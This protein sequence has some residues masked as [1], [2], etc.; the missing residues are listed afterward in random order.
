MWRTMSKLAIEQL[1]PHT[2]LGAKTATPKL[3]EGVNYFARLQ[4]AK[5]GAVELLLQTAQGSLKL[6]LTAAPDIPLGLPLMVTLQRA[7]S[8]STLLQIKVLAALPQE[9]KL[10]PAQAQLLQD[11]KQL[12]LLQ[13]QLQRNAPPALLAAEPFKLTAGLS[14]L[15]ATSP[16]NMPKLL[17]QWSAPAGS[18]SSVLQLFPVQQEQTV[19][20]E[21][22]NLLSPL[23][24]SSSTAA[25]A[26]SPKAPER[27]TDVSW[28]Q[29]LPLLLQQPAKLA[30]L[31]SL[32]EPVLAILQQVRQAQPDGQ[33]LL[34]AAQVEQQLLAALQFQPLQTQ[35]NLQT[36][37]GSL[38]VAIQLLLGHL[39][40]K[41]LTQTRAATAALAQ[42]VAQLDPQQAG[43]LLRALGSH[44]SVLQLAQLQNLEQPQLNQQWF[45]PLAVQQQQESRIVEMLLERREAEQH[46][47][48][49]RQTQWQLSMKFDLA[50]AGQLLAVAKLGGQQLQ[51]QFYTEQRSAL[52]QA[53]KFLPLLTERLHAQGLTVSQASCQLGKIPD[54]LGTRRTSLISTQA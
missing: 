51:L 7:T 13:Q 2:A 3:S 31:P 33:R 6:A 28:R 1:L 44:S 25:V 4:P 39:L 54:T 30:V 23:P 49:T 21:Q 32:P 14:S 40:R 38:A 8:Q 20:L 48:E 47:E 43:Q 27:M 5:A 53:E 42:Q 18:G 52:K 19:K 16:A 41:P 15:L 37:A 10:T 11:P 50:T 36:S 34:S 26:A 45:I 35:P 46:Q 12:T 29:L 17:L 22:K 24:W 9:I